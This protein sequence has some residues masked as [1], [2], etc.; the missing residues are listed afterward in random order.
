[1]TNV[2]SKPP[3]IIGLRKQTYS[4]MYE[5]KPWQKYHIGKNII[6]SQNDMKYEMIYERI[7]SRIHN[8]F[9]NLRDIVPGLKNFIREIVN[10]Q[11]IDTH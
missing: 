9:G 1:M 11:Q 4:D 6:E 3:T 5:E 8:E 10:S 7:P 2:G